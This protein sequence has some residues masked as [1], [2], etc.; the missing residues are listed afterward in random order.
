M[1]VDVWLEYVLELTIL[2][3]KFIIL[4][5]GK[6]SS[7]YFSVLVSESVYLIILLLNNVSNDIDVECLFVFDDF[8]LFG[9]DLYLDLFVGRIL[10]IFDLVDVN[11]FPKI[12]AFSLRLNLLSKFSESFLFCLLKDLS[13]VNDLS[14][15]FIFLINEFDFYF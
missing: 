4:I 14:L 5:I 15:Y 8:G 2:L 1:F 12:F 10:I 7:L 11:I 13:F 3:S 6:Q 9:N